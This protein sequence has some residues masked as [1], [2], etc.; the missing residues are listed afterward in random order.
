MRRPLPLLVLFC[1]ACSAPPI[2]TTTSVTTTTEAPST[3][4]AATTTEAVTTTTEPLPASPINGLPV[5]DVENL[6]RR[7]IAVKIDNHPNAR[8]QSGLD[9]AEAVIE[10]PVEGLTRFIALFHSTDAEY[11]GPVRSGRPSDGRLLNPLNATMAISGGQDWVI[12]GLRAEVEGIIGEVRPAM[13]RI[14][15]RRAP[16]DLYTSTEALRQI[17]DERDYSDEPPTAWYVFED[18]PRSAERASQVVMNFGNSFL[19]TWEYNPVARKYARIYA[20]S[21][22][23]GLDPDGDSYEITAD[24]L[25][26]IIARRYTE[27]APAGQTSVP[28]MDTVGTGTAYVFSQGGVLEGTWSRESS[29]DHLILRDLNGDDMAVPPGYLWISI[30][31]EQNGISFE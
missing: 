27:Q 22:S 10:V 16:H 29:D 3:T 30:V 15:G 21:P 28:A 4:E 11:L 1:V 12:A 20:G 17:A 24:S 25:V 23:E 14:D 8:P 2:A 31:P 13:F 18:M 7:V 5:E 9:L 19:V 6:D 26:V